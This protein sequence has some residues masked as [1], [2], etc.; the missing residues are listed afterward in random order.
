MC[1]YKLLGAAFPGVFWG[2][3]CVSGA[4]KKQNT[5]R[6]SS[7][8]NTQ[9]R[10]LFDAEGGSFFERRKNFRAATLAWELKN[11]AAHMSTDLRFT[12]PHLVAI[13][14]IYAAD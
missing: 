11:A 6:K 2:V 3:D 5:A 8:R 14:R 9:I 7:A 13:C 4:L 10:G 1:F 12:T